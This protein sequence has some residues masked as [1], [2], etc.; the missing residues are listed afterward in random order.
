MAE[1]S[2]YAARRIYCASPHDRRRRNRCRRRLRFCRVCLHRLPLFG[3]RYLTRRARESPR[4]STWELDSH[5]RAQ[6]CRLLG[7][8]TTSGEVVVHRLRALLCARA[9]D[10]LCKDMTTQ[11]CLAWRLTCGFSFLTQAQI[12]LISLYFPFQYMYES[13]NIPLTISSGTVRQICHLCLI[14]QSP[15]SWIRQKKTTFAKKIHNK[16]TRNLLK[17]QESDFLSVTRLPISNYFF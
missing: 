1:T 7:G 5:L 11:L 4:C 14:I 2:A 9:S 15:K 16:S 6:R 17:S 3:A 10:D 8:A 13:L 12:F